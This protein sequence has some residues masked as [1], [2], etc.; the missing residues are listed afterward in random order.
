[1]RLLRFILRNLSS[2]KLWELHKYIL[3]NLNM[4]YNEKHIMINDIIYFPSMDK[5]R[6]KKV[7][8]I[9]YNS[10][11]ITRIICNNSTL[12]YLQNHICYKCYKSLKDCKGH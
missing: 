1:M 8:R 10:E 9:D 5:F 4:S 11:G 2:K 3:R 12:E 6:P 7:I